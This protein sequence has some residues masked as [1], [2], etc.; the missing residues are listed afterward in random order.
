[1]NIDEKSLVVRQSNEL[2][3]ASYKIA[4]I[5]E[6]R[7]MRMLI[8]QIKPD[9]EDF[10]TYRIGVADFAR[11]FGITHNSIHE[12]IEKSAR[13]LREREIYI[14]K[15]KSWFSTGWLS[16][17]KYTE[18]SGFIEVRFDKELKPYLLGLKS[19]FTQ[20]ELEKV[21][22]FKSGYAM[23]LFELLKKEQFK[24]DGKGYFKRSFE[25]DEL[26][27]FLGIDKKEY[28]FFKDFRVNVVQVA[29]REINANPDISI[30]KVDYPKTGRKVSH[31]VFHCE[32]AKQL[33]LD[34]DEP[35]PTLEEVPARK[36]HPEYISEL[37]AIGIDEQTAYRWKR[38]YTVA[39]LHQAIAYTKAMQ[40]KGKIR[41][42]VTGF[43][44]NAITNN[45]GASWV[46]D[47]KKKEQVKNATDT[48]ERQKQ[49]AEAVRIEQERAEREA[50]LARFNALPDTDKAHI[51]ASYGASLKGIVLSQWEKAIKANPQSPETSKPVFVSFLN[52]YKTF[53]PGERPPA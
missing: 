1:M 7:L 47:R 39:R 51:R 37:I 9:D 33:Q 41:D 24:A 36:E 16:S 30:I 50:T 49:E 28:A 3:E 38:K 14:R 10:K 20:Y 12:Q 15:G 46:E 25:Y 5:G 53:V 45:I 8:A 6:G 2:I 23:R 32:K 22:N 17:A 40:E 11:F 48:A 4:S 43:L 27:G 52:F 35:A 31:I 26:R 29:I 42:S 44:A 21:V 34:I 19:Y 13:A 18:G